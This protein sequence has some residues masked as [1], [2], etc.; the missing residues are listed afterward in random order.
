MSPRQKLSRATERQP[1]KCENN[2]YTLAKNTLINSSSVNSPFFAGLT[3]SMAA[4]IRS[5][6]IVFPSVCL[7]N[8]PTSVASMVCPALKVLQIWLVILKN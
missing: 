2:N 5:K 4:W 1:K 6:G 8:L 7:H 3:D